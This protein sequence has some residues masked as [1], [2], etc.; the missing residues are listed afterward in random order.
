VE[1][2]AGNFDQ[3]TRTLSI[4]DTTPPTISIRGGASIMHEAATPYTDSGATAFDTLDGDVSVAVSGEV[5]TKPSQ[6]PAMFTLTYT[7]VDSAG[8]NQAAKRTI[9]VVDTTPPAISLL[10]DDTAQGGATIPFGTIYR[11]P[12]VQAVDSYAGDVSSRVVAYGSD[13][14]DVLQAGT[15][16]ITYTA[17]DDYGNAV[18]TYRAVVVQRFDLSESTPLVRLVLSFDITQNSVSLLEAAF[19]SALGNAFVFIVTFRDHND[20]NKDFNLLSRFNSGRQQPDDLPQSTKYVVDFAAR[21]YLTLDWIAASD[22]LSVLS[23]SSVRGVL[24]EAGVTVTAAI[25][26]KGPTSFPAKVHGTPVAAASAA[27]AAG[28]AAFVLVVVVTS[29]F[30]RRRRT[31]RARAVFK[32]DVV[33]MLTLDRSRIRL[34]AQLGSFG[35]AGLLRD[36]WVVMQ[37]SFG[38]EEAYLALEAGTDVGAFK[39]QADLRAVAGD[40]RN[41][42]GLCGRC[43][44]SVPQLLLFERVS[45]GNL[46]DQLRS[47]RSVDGGG[48]I[49][50]QQIKALC[51]GVSAGLGHVH[52]AGVALGYVCA[53]NVALNDQLTPKLSSFAYARR[54][55]PDA[56][57]GAN[58]LAALLGHE[59]HGRWLAPETLS[60]TEKGATIAGDIWALGVTVWEICTL[61]ATPY[62][63]LQETKDVLASLSQK[64][65]LTFPA[66]ATRAGAGELSNLCWR[67]LADMRGN[68]Q[69]VRD[70][71]RRFPS[72]GA[73]ACDDLPPV[74]PWDTACA[75]V[76]TGAIAASEARPR[77]RTGARQRTATAVS[78]TRGAAA[79]DWMRYNPTYAGS[80]RSTNDLPA[81]Y[82]V[83]ISAMEVS[84][85]PALPGEYFHPKTMYGGGVTSDALYATVEGEVASNA[86]ATLSL[87]PAS[88]YSRL[89]TNHEVYRSSCEG[90]AAPP[91]GLTS[92]PALVPGYTALE[93]DHMVYGPVSLSVQA[94]AGENDDSY[95]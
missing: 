6:V 21:D 94:H 49:S 38:G 17:E 29:L 64:K 68:A 59:L 4:I 54:I 13:T 69:Q 65:R 43:P 78:T 89:T 34:G 71:A 95:I 45:A 24:L 58:S 83:S 22:I 25:E 15:Y 55:L 47:W 67:T 90:V 50:L 26:T 28:A 33:D 80:D 86:N 44:G 77:L 19:S 74:A 62:I 91:G 2:K 60:G 11:D 52:G 72:D 7:A 18:T 31:S 39:R 32:S 5:I 41:I 40:D 10:G 57:D 73:I 70:V 8:N 14:I 51:I 35:D 9:D 20:E 37:T 56:A 79:A 3:V 88:G 93:P 16:T 30:W 82:G 81:T 48:Q 87:T 42:L 53:A 23:N 92:M 36:A 75:S 12:G 1:D 76:S 61:A 46:R 27:G 84:A 85:L 63:S 66:W